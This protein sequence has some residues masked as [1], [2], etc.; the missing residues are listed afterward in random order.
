MS[1]LAAVPV[2]HAPTLDDAV[3]PGHSLAAH[4]VCGRSNSVDPHTWLSLGY[5]WRALED[6]SGRLRCVC[7]ARAARLTDEAAP[8]VAGERSIYIF[9]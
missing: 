9:R 6:L 1:C 7:G 3:R 2:A 8:A 5:G 4:C